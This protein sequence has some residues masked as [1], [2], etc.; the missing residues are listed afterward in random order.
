VKVEL[1]SVR[2][3]HDESDDG[4]R[5]DVVAEVQAERGQAEAEQASHDDV[6]S[7]VGVRQEAD[8]Q[9]GQLERNAKD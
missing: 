8:D 1:T 2:E 9:R 7:S 3:G 6:A 4:E 5:E